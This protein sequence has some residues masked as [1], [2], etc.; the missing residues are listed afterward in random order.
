MPP[1]PPSDEDKE[2]LVA[3]AR[4]VARAGPGGLS[5]AAVAE[6]CGKAPAVVTR[7]F[8]SRRDLLLAVARFCADHAREV[9]ADLRAGAASPVEALIHS[10]L[11]FVDPGAAPDHVAHHLAFLQLDVTD[12]DL[13]AIALGQLRDLEAHGAAL[14]R[15]AVRL[16]ELRPCDE[17]GLARALQVAYSGGLLRWGLTQE[18][19]VR[20]T[21]AA[22]LSAALGPWRAR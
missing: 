14:I 1:Q 13:R 5:P 4:V 17:A 7:R 9:L 3:A 15:D 20:D 19:S 22:D 8:G 2:I 10:Y 18:G 11:A 6:A 21:L 16:G 12:P